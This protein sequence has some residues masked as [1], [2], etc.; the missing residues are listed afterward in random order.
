VV[1]VAEHP[2]DVSD[3]MALDVA[4]WRRVNF[5][6]G[7]GR[8]LRSTW[9]GA[10]GDVAAVV[11]GQRSRRRDYP[12]TDASAMLIGEQ[13]A[14]VLDEGSTL[15]DPVCVALDVSPDRRTASSRRG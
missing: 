9:R 15:Q 3:E 11:R 14:D 4:L 6:I 8:V 10:A 13:W 5:A 7:H 1:V 2:N 12:A